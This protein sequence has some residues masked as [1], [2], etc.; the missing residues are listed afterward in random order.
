MN[1]HLFY[2]GGSGGLFGAWHLLQVNDLNCAF[3]IEDGIVAKDNVH[4]VYAENK[5]EELFGVVYPD[6]LVY[7]KN[8]PI[9][10]TQYNTNEF[11][12]W[13]DFLIRTRN[14]KYTFR[15]IYN[16]EW[17]K[18][19][20]REY[21]KHTENSPNNHYTEF[22]HCKNK[23]YLTCNPS[24]QDVKESS[25]DVKI[26][27]YTDLESQVALCHYK[28]VLWRH[29]RY[30]PWIEPKHIASAKYA[31]D[32]VFEKVPECAKHCT[33]VVKLQDVI[34]TAGGALTETIGVSPNDDNIKHNKLWLS[35]HEFDILDKIG[36]KKT[37]ES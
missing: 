2:F 19:D 18:H 26:M 5:W 12:D 6:D 3:M 34:N 7:A 28:G 15:D 11:A 29:I 22:L 1:V 36:I 13:A 24:V 16:W 30:T 17:D 37:Y 31:D 23:F 20:N 25:A 9:P 35:F 8:K 33:H 10:T 32:I 4:Y 14:H 27:L 21:W